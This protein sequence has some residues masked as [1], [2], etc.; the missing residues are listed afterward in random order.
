MGRRSKKG[1]PEDL[2]LKLI[3]LLQD[4]EH[5]LT[6]GN[7]RAQ[8]KQLIP[9]HHN[10]RDLGSS[11]M[12]GPETESGLTRVLAYL[13]KFSGQVMQGEE[14]MVVAGIDDYA[15]RIRELRVQGGWPI[16]SGATAKDIKE[17]DDD[18][19]AATPKMK[20]NDYMLVAD[21]QDRDAAHRWHVANSIR[22]KKEDV[23]D[24]ILEYLLANVG[25]VVSGEELRYVAR[26]RSEWAR[27]TREL[28]T[29]KGWRIVTRATGRPTMPVGSYLLESNIQAP[30]QDRKIPDPIR[31]AVLKRDNYSCVDCGWDSRTA[32]VAAAPKHLELHHKIPHVKGGKN[33]VENLL[34]LCNICHDERHRKGEL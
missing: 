18:D 13:R 9:V 12:T 7:L 23:Q 15:R 11:L 8:V 24:R 3:N 29:E 2:R 5:H 1:N 26:N 6:A 32:F 4:F 30:P 21:E 16:L 31:H 25:K 34:T 33:T 14:L 27:R 28:R 17:L 20:P 10:L 19:A 22:K